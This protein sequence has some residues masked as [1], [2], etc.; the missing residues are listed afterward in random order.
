MINVDVS[1][2]T[3]R[4]GR[5]EHAHFELPLEKKIRKFIVYDMNNIIAY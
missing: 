3:Y 2:Q 1:A 5:E 4:H